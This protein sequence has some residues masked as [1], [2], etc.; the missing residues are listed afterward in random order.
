MW[1]FLLKLSLL[2]GHEAILTTSL[3]QSSDSTKIKFTLAGV[4]TGMEDEIKRNIEGY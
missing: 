4:P 3:D 2:P 1:V